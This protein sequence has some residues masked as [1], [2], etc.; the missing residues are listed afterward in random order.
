MQEP[1]NLFR[2]V[3]KAK[4]ERLSAQHEKNHNIYQLINNVAQHGCC[5]ARQCSTRLEN[6]VVEKAQQLCTSY[7]A[8]KPVYRDLLQHLP[9]CARAGTLKDAWNVL[10]IHVDVLEFCQDITHAVFSKR[11]RPRSSSLRSP[12]PR[13]NQL[14]PKDKH[15][16]KQFQYKCLGQQ[17][18]FQEI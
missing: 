7:S 8:W 4:H 2:R 17:N 10:K 5:L 16:R 14:S 9:Q 12:L 13:S 15:G 1:H 18:H 11:D 6:N 3:D